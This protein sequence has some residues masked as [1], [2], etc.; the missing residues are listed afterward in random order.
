[1]FVILDSEFFPFSAV[2][3]D[4]EC[5]LLY[6]WLVLT[7]KLNGAASKIKIFSTL[8]DNL[9]SIIIYCR[10]MDLFSYMQL[11]WG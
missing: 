9:K 3:W 7:L 4:G 8:F 11:V 6:F 10:L 5:M 2:V 1:M